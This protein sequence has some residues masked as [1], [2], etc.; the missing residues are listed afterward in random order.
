[1]NASG[2]SGGGLISRIS[3]WGKLLKAGAYG[4]VVVV[5]YLVGVYV[6]LENGLDVVSS[7]VSEPG[8]AYASS[9]SRGDEALSLTDRFRA[10]FMQSLAE[11]YFERSDELPAPFV[12]AGENLAERTNNWTFGL[13]W[14]GVAHN[15][16]RTDPL[17]VSSVDVRVAL[18]E[19]RPFPWPE[20]PVTPDV[21]VRTGLRFISAEDVGLGPAMDVRW[22]ISNPALGTV[23]SGSRDMLYHDSFLNEFAGASFCDGHPFRLWSVGPGG[24]LGSSLFL[25]IPPPSE[26]GATRFEFE[27]QWYE[28]IRSLERLS[29]VTPT[30]SNDSLMLRLGFTSLVGEPFEIDRV[31][32]IPD[33]IA[34]LTPRE[35]LL[36]Y[37]PRLPYSCSIVS[38]GAIDLPGF[39]L[40]VIPQQF[41]GLGVLERPSGVDVLVERLFVDAAS[42]EEGKS[43][44]VGTTPDVFLNPK[45]AL[46]VYLELD[47]P[48]NGTYD[49]EWWVNG[50]LVNNTALEALVPNALR[51]DPYEHI[52]WFRPGG[53]H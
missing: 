35:E 29:E 9:P 14:K 52:D 7:T 5:G 20:L 44:R 38:P 16:S 31:T 23:E 47:R 19:S 28:E 8:V 32:A 42:L 21:D 34:M 17:F 13:T 26:A 45:G 39:L 15:R 24:R 49:I 3:G 12:S 36:E 22:E 51:F 1:M 43:T 46:S 33:T 40:A 6:R 48:R 18:A 11:V 10:E 41:T 27:G 2:G 50:E 53:E 37:D 30:A 4:A 25:E